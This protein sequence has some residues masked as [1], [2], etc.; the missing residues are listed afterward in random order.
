MMLGKNFWLF[1]QA[2]VISLVGSQLAFIA[3]SF[4]ILSQL[5]SGFKMSIIMAPAKL[6]GLFFLL[7]L[8]PLADVFRRKIFLIIGSFLNVTVWVILFF[9]LAVHKLDFIMLICLYIFD[10]IANS[11]FSAG[12]SGFLPELVPKE[13][14]QKAFRVSSGTNS[15]VKIL[16]GLFAGIVVSIL[17]TAVAFI[18]NAGSF[19]VVACTTL[20]IKPQ[21]EKNK[22]KFKRDNISETF[23]SWK[24]DFMS[25]VKFTFGIKTLRVI[26]IALFLMQFVIIPMQIALPVFVKIH[27]HATSKFFGIV[28]SVDGLGAILASIFLGKI[29]CI[30]TEEKLF[31]GGILLVSASIFLLGIFPYKYTALL[32][33]MLSSIGLTSSSIVLNTVLLKI[34]PDKLR[35]RFFTILLFAEGIAIPVGLLGA[36]Y[37]IDHFGVAK[38]FMGMGFGLFIICLVTIYFRLFSFLSNPAGLEVANVMGKLPSLA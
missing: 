22:L 29:S 31:V 17:G 26:C 16:G 24:N 3:V 4:Y 21:H 15:V 1:R 33:L 6:G 36:G 38:V 11:I 37:C 12:A 32:F 7:F 10:A 2:Q 30:L 25:G 19:L 35:S 34:I 5:G 23:K 27:L 13:L 28:L 8:G 9:L 20:F 14:F 18:L